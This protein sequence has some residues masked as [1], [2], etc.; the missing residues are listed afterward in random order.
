MGDMR[1]LKQQIFEPC[2][3]RIS[4]SGADGKPFGAVWHG[5]EICG[6]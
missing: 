6:T 3:K 2:P 5:E 4:G 1:D